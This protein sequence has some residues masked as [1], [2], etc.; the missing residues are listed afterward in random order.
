MNYEVIEYNF[1]KLTKAIADL[2]SE[3]ELVRK[4]ALSD[5]KTEL[6]CFFKDFHCAEAIFTLNTDNEFFGIQ[7]SPF[8]A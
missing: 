2:T 8:F 7:I 1:S 4:S 3:N 5:I 6:N